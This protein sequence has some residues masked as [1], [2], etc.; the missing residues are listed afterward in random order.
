MYGF[1]AKK[2]FTIIIITT[3][4][5]YV[6]FLKFKIQLFRNNISYLSQISFSFI[7]SDT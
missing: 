1:K 5:N 7:R 6:L 3:I 2:K 4:I